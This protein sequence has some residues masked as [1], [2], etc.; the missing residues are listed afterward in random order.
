MDILTYLIALS[1]TVISVVKTTELFYL[2]DKSLN[3]V[4]S[5][6]IKKT[7]SLHNNQKGNITYIAILFVLVVSAMLYFYVSKMKIEYKEAQ[8][9]NDSYLCFRFLN[10]KTEGYI[11]DMAR[12][13]MALRT[14]FASKNTVINGASGELVFRGLVYAR[15]ARHFYYLKQLAT[16]NYCEKSDSL[17]YF[18]Q[19]PF[20]TDGA[21]VLQTNI[22][23][24]T[25]LRTAE[26][27]SVIYKTPK[28][29]RVRKSF[30]LKTH[31]KIE[32]A[33]FPNLK[34]NSEEIPVEGISSL[35]CLSG[36]PSSS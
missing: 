1:L 4:Q 32:G 30:C 36:S 24:T 29:I 10:K 33:F 26:W 22:D 6:F 11:A 13:N 16:N 5:D 20:Q 34:M 28:G 2:S 8:Y 21:G 15:N 18:S 23:E 7:R 12:F 31:F 19:L 14:A 35:K 17:S 9:R 3:S 27:T 25:K